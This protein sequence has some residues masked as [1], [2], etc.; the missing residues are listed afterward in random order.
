MKPSGFTGC[1]SSDTPLTMKTARKELIS[2]AKR[3]AGIGSDL[4][5][6]LN[7]AI[8]ALA[9]QALQGIVMFYGGAPTPVGRANIDWSGP[10]H[11][12]QEWPAQLNRFFQLAPLAAAYR[13]TGDEKYAECA[14]D[15]IADWIRA[16]PTRAG[17]EI[18]KHDNTLNLSI[19]VGQG[20]HPG[21]LGTLP[22]FLK[23]PAFDDAF[24]ESIF[25]SVQAQ[26]GFLA[27]RLTPVGNWRISQ[28][29]CFL[30]AGLRLTFLPEAE[31]WRALG[32]RILNDAFHRQVLPD[33]VHVERNPNYHG[34]MRDVMER[35][36][37]LGE[38]MPELGLAITADAVARMHDYGLA[39]TNPN[40][41]LSPLHDGS[42][43]RTRLQ[44][45][46]AL[47]GAI[48]R[49]A[50]FRKK[51]GLTEIPPP[52]S[53]FFPDAGQAFL[54]DGWGADAVYATFDATPWGG[55][56]C[57]LS[58]NAV[59]VHAYGRSL[60]VDPGSLTYEMTDPFAPHGK[61]TRAHN[62]LNLNGWNQSLCDLRSTRVWTGDGYDFV[63]STYQ[64]GYWPGVYKWW[65]TEGH[66]SGIWAGHSRT[67]LWIRNRCIVILDKIDRT[68]EAHGAASH[69][70]PSLEANWQLC[71]GP[72]TLDPSARRAV[73]GHP[74]ANLLL[75]FPLVADGME[76]S[77]HEGEIDPPRGWLTG[78]SKGSKYT[79]APQVV[80]RSAP[81]R[82]W[83]EDLATVLVPFRG[84]RAPAVSAKAR[85]PTKAGVR[86]LT[87]DWEDGSEDTIHWTSTLHCMI[88]VHEGI[89]TD[90][91]LVH[92]QKN[93]DR[94]LAKGLVVEGTYCAPFASKA[95]T[96]PETFGIG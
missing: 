69:T 46:N 38:K 65:F 64:G 36:W 77:I 12:H 42:S 68:F 54:R 70:A 41:F 75:L 47:N 90:A 5:P 34:W 78:A 8:Q 32:A 39:A 11:K 72:V 74:D 93:R 33:G 25:R 89:S 4:I 63:T 45:N 26:L 76:L 73:T 7:T 87:I 60:L 35:L 84:E 58:R 51:A 24:L 59:Q 71:E 66:G 94:S 50:A 14:R 95:R 62:T 6:A 15:F 80:L 43:P 1:H 31:G 30:W 21:W 53:W 48:S 37:E 2:N 29:E 17:W 18:A 28:A 91:G 19:R 23:S 61:S 22:D 88:G 96:R 55:S 82:R 85:G 83:T 52:A 16:H 49:R 40:G 44:P 13:K 27:D 92:L 67:L 86:S 3:L 9:D 20:Q 57:H 10:Q 56:H 79:P 81:M